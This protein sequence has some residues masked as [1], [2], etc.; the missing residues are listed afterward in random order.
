MIGTAADATFLARSIS[1]C[2]INASVEEVLIAVESECA[3]ND[4]RYE[5]KHTTYY[6]GQYAR[7]MKR[8]LL[9]LGFKV[10]I[11]PH[12][13]NTAVLFVSWRIEE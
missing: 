4:C 3:T 2:S 5:I 10:A 1:K 13:D 7:I 6:G 12:R 9:E 11:H 8:F